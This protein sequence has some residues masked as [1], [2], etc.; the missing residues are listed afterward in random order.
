MNEVFKILKDGGFVV[1]L[2]EQMPEERLKDTEFESRMF[3]SW[4]E[5]FEVRLGLTCITMK[6]VEDVL[7]GKRGVLCCLKKTHASSNNET[8]L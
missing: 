7:K 2:N 5:D 6:E 1:W 4:L 8:S 3:E